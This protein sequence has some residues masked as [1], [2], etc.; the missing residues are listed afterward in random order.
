M[1]VSAGL[2]FCGRLMALIAFSLFAVA[3]VTVIGV[4]AGARFNAADGLLPAIGF[5]LL[6]VASSAGIGLAIGSL[7]HSVQGAIF[8]GVGI[9]VLTGFVSGL[10]IPYSS[11]PEALKAFARIYPIASGSS[12]ASYFLLGETITGY[13]PVTPIQVITTVVLSL[14]LLGAGIFLYS[15]VSWKR[16]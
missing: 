8:T 15:R 2:D 10:F 11:L 1:P 4:I 6:V 14:V 13:N 12:S 9:S 5:L 16:E 7:V 3:V